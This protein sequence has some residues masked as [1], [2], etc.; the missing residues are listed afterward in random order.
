MRISTAVVPGPET[1]A[2]ET[3]RTLFDAQRAAFARGAPDYAA[4]MDALARL[5]EA[6]NVRREELVRAV[7][8]DFGGRARE[9]TLLLEI[10]PLLDQIRHARRHLGR[11]MKRRR[12][13]SSW[14]L[15]PSRA[16]YQYQP[17]GVAGI[18]G[19]WN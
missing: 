6:I 8:D 19:A 15:L 10:F 18:I 14:F 2:P 13:R 4:R 12:V 9:E 3:L 7:S 1:V 17:L 5:R 11:W 16:F